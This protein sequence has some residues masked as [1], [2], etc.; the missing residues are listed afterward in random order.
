MS[1]NY[2][3][4]I[5]YFIAILDSNGFR[6]DPSSDGRYMYEGHSVPRVTSILEDT[7]NEPYIA[8]WANWLG[9]CH[10]SYRTELSE[11]AFIGT[12]THSY[13]ENYC[14]DKQIP[15]VSKEQ[16]IH[17]VSA[18]MKWWT[19]LTDNNNIQI[20]GQEQ[21][22]ACPW[23]GGTYDMLLS[24][25]PKSDTDP[26]SPSSLY[27]IDFKTS[28]QI[29]FRYYMQL[30]AY[31]YLIETQNRLDITGCMILRLDKKTGIFEE[32]IVNLK[33]PEGK[34][35]MEQCTLGFFSCVVSYYFRHAIHNSTMKFRKGV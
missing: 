20:V 34:A 1:L 6:G 33:T 14:Q 5:N 12:T 31:K 25:K 35:F 19:Q 4:M 16:E 30:A 15:E 27:L 11:A 23:F 9:F 2:E 28:S 22:M 26:Y 21:K 24:V 17:C 8:E 18:F 3:E 7:I 10:K 29:A 32:S 13:I